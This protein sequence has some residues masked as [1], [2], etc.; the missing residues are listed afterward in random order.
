MVTLTV[1]PPG[2]YA[3]RVYVVFVI[4][5]TTSE[6][7]AGRDAGASSLPTITTEAAFSVF[8]ARVT[9]APAASEVT[10]SDVNDRIRTWPTFTVT[11]A[12]IWPLALVA[13][14]V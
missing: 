1:C 4:G 8:H 3:V 6:P 9:G 14:S 10:G 13:V 7:L 12:W 5:F 11:L 2:P